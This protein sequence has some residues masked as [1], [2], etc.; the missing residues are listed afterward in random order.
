MFIV[1]NASP[2]D[3]LE[4]IRAW[5]AALE[6]EIPVEIIA[7]PVNGGFAAGNNLGL[8]H[9]DAR[10]CVLL[11]SDTIVQPDAIETMLGAM[12]KN[13]QLGI[14]G[15][16][17]TDESGAP[18]I[19]RFRRPSPLGEFV[20]AT[21][22]DVF[23]KMFPNRV[24]PIFDEESNDEIEWIGFPCVML[25]RKMIDEIGLLDENYFMYFEDIAYC[26]RAAAA[27]WRIEYCKD[28]VVQHFCGQSSQIEKNTAEFNRLPRYYYASRS[29]YFTA[30]YGT[31]GYV[32]ANLFWYFG[33]LFAYL[34]VLLFKSPKK[35]SKG[36]G[37]DIWIRDAG[38]PS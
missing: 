30:T 6:T 22:A 21:G 23:Y 20:A 14:L 38:Q 18:A 29:R 31:P 13:P 35:T 11:N 37:A 7:S 9:C 28:A 16:Q 1:D 3:S 8:K 24:V 25:N 33:R 27:G 32:A 12:K 26:D 5:R 10:Y 17:I 34:R 36:R 4:K 15:P 2:D 19:S